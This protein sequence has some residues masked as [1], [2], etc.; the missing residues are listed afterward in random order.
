[1]KDPES[2]RWVDDIHL[3]I[4]DTEWLDHTERDLVFA[5]NARQLFKL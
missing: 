1:V 3:L 5:G 2:G 4:D